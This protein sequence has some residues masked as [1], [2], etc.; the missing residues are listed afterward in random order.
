MRDS[1]A[2]T[3]AAVLARG[4]AVSLAEP[5][6]DVRQ[7]LRLDAYAGVADSDLDLV[8]SAPQSRFNAPTFV[9]ELDRV[10]EQIP[11][12]LLQAAGVAKNNV[13]VGVNHRGQGHP[14]H[15]SAWP[16][17][18]NGRLKDAFDLDRL[19]VEFET[20]SDDARS[21]ED[22]IYQPSL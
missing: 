14:F 2:E 9:R 7:E 21:V 4:R 15:F 5:L 18:I 16:D 13:A 1:Q 17:D 6:E 20:T 8:S 12:G 19:G 3:Q 11:Y 10:R 22:V